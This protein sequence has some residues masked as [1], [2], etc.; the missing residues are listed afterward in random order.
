MSGRTKDINRKAISNAK[1]VTSRKGRNN[2]GKECGNGK[3][4][5]GNKTKVMREDGEKVNRSGYDRGNVGKRHK[6]GR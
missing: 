6:Q 4:Q 1:K 5:E 3:R 2:E